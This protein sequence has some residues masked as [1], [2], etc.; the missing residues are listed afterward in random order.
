M[1]CVRY[2]KENKDRK[3]FDELNSIIE[4]IKQKYYSRL[5]NKLIDPVSSSKVYWPTLKM[6]LINEKISCIPPLIHQN[7]YVSDFKE[8]T[9]ICNSFWAMFCDE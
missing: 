6:F 7:K 8:K 2:V 9:E 3:V 4:C 5:L 1:K